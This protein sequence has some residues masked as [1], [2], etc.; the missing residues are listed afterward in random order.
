MD[1]LFYLKGNE[2]T[3]HTL[4]KL[5]IKH[6]NI[7]SAGTTPQTSAAVPDTSGTNSLFQNN[8]LKVK[9]PEPQL[10]T[11]HF[12]YGVAGILFF[13][14]VLFVWLYAVN[15]KRLNQ[16]IKAFYINR[17]AN[18][19]A[20]EEISI[21][22]RVTIFLSAMFVLT[23]ALFITQLANYY[24]FYKG[25]NQFIFFIKVAVTIVGAYSLKIFSVWFFGYIFQ[26]PKEASDY[27]TA[28]F[29]FCNTLG[30]FML[31][32]VIGLAFAKQIAPEIFVYS[33]YLIL[34][35]F[36]CIRLLRGVIIGFNSV[37]ISKFYLFLYLCTLEILPFVIMVKLFILKI[38]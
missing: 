10:H 29:L 11:T 4:P 23:L 26:N 7:Q 8:F 30:L 20:R 22:N 17:Y 19:L 35:S 38:K 34:G 33:G 3:L 2:L 13:A 15:R 24:G 16:V 25:D 5:P 32:I 21:G 14:F 1:N 28:I 36:L 27:S 37:R 31:P 9:T 18:Q 6:I 12:D